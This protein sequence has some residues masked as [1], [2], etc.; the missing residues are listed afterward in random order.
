[1]ESAVCSSHPGHGTA[2]LSKPNEY[3]NYNSSA[4]CSAQ[5]KHVRSRHPVIRHDR[6]SEPRGFAQRLVSV[7]SSKR[8][9]PFLRSHASRL[10]PSTTSIYAR[11]QTP[12]LANRAVRRFLVDVFFSHDNGERA[13]P[14]SRYPLTVLLRNLPVSGCGDIGRPIH[15]HW[16]FCDRRIIWSDNSW[17]SAWV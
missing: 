2:R 1:M 17:A 14:L 11:V 10:H 15:C 5:R 12:A 9:K 13:W 8:V 7:V 3:T 6:P 16:E 4:C